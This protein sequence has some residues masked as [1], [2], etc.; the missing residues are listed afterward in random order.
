MKDL[1]AQLATTSNALTIEEI[2]LHIVASALFGAI[3]YLSYWFTH[4]GTAYSKKFNV[5]LV[6]LATLTG[7][8]MT[9]IGDNIVLSLGMVGALSIVRFRTPIKDS[10]DTMYI[11]WS[12][13]VGIC[14]G[15]G[16]YVVAAIGSA[17]IFLLLVALG[18]VRNEN[19][20]LLI[21]RGDR[22]KTSDMERLVS[23]YFNKRAI[24]RVRN[25]ETDSVELIY[26]MPRKIWELNYKKEVDIADALYALGGIEYVNTVT[27]SDEI[28]G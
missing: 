22:G 20:I 2:I 25:T 16:G 12:I 17:V 5:S 13:V 7:T 4:T 6:A 24:L 19:R 11:F 8:V 18:R 21:M 15:V 1:I 3:I 10:R 28:T 14:C 23:D 26:E 9:V 27:Q